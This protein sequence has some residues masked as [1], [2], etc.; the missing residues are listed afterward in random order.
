MVIIFILS[1]ALFFLDEEDFDALARQTQA[2]GETVRPVLDEARLWLAEGQKKQKVQPG[3]VSKAVKVLVQPV[4]L[5]ANDRVFEAVGTG[6]ARLSLQ[7]YP[8]VAEEV[9][10]V[11]FQA[12][13]RV[14]QGD[15]LVQLD[16]REEVLAIR[17][18][19]IQL[20]NAR[21][22][23][24][25]YEKAVKEGAVPESE[26]D[27]VRADFEAA[28]VALDQAKLALEDRRIKAPF[29]GVVGIP[30]IDPG[31]RVTT[32]TIITSLDD[33]KILHVD[34]EV[35]EALAGALGEAQS[36]NRSIT[37]TTPA[38]PGRVFVATISAQESRVNADRRTIL[39][40]TSIENE[41][42]LLRPGMSFTTRWTISGKRYP[43]IPEISLQWGRHGSFVWL[44]RKQKAVQ[45]PVQVIARKAGNVLV[46]GR[47]ATREPVV[48][49]GIQRMRP[50]AS[51]HIV[52]EAES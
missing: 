12:Q 35:P 52:G 16:D 5:T 15:L 20:K 4:R 42:D 44:V 23:L 17:K 32:T 18:A 47:L 22:L 49:E 1:L 31:Q 45:V 37:A 10:K 33:R 9:T 29:D 40:R 48:V 43:T 46:E 41:E 51:L 11:L 34:F 6:R 27:T 36:E 13:D 7:I 14:S 24:S 2:V 50:G 39:A 26:V 30:K 25:R 19:E 28:A 38:Y 21:S 8:T 3:K